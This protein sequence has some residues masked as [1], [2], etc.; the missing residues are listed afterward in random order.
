MGQEVRGVSEAASLAGGGVGQYLASQRRL[1]GIS[2]D[3]LAGLTKI[4]RRS[5]ERLE[6]GTFDA[7]PD[8]FVRGFVRSVADSLGL[9]PDE[10]VMRLMDEPAPAG[11]VAG[12]G[13]PAGARWLFHVALGAMAVAVLAGLVLA[14]RALFAPAPPGTPED[15]IL[16]RDPVRSLAA[17]PAVPAEVE[18]APA[19][20]ALEVG[21]PPAP[22]VEPAAP[23]APAIGPGAPPAPVEPLAPRTP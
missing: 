4:P 7:A 2:L 11:Q 3:E 1:R 15:V 5:L 20:P 10:A 12:D 8:G 22:A 6:A 9:D 14:A 16:R 21:A 17:D 23:T 18:A 13:Q 19:Q